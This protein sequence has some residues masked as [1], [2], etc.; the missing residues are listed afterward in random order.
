[1][2]NFPLALW[3]KDHNDDDDDDDDDPHLAKTWKL[4]MMM[5]HIWQKHGS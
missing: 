2:A 1:M 5:I 3:E 4:M